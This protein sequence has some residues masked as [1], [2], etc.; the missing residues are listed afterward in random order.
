MLQGDW[1]FSFVSRMNVD[2]LILQRLPAT[3]YVIGSAQLLAL[4][5]AIPVG[6]YA[7][8]KPYS[9]FDQIA[10][11]LRLHRL[12]AADLLHRPAV[13]PAVFDHAGLAAFVYTTDIKGDR[14]PLG[15]RNRFGKPSWPVMCSACFRR[16]P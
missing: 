2:T 6:V 11:T 4:A 12:F 9:I 13:H 8:T 10:N 1:G 7:A 3:L 16:P 14:L 5:I 15:D